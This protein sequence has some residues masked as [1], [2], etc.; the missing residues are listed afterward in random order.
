[1]KEKL[2]HD[3]VPGLVFF[4]PLVPLRTTPS[5]QFHDLPGGFIEY[6]HSIDRVHHDVGAFS[7]IAVNRPDVRAWYMHP[8]Q[9]DNLLVLGGE[10]V[11]ELYTST[12]GAIETFVVT[13]NSI[14]HRGKEIH[15]GPALLGW[16]T[17]VFHRVTSPQGSISMNFARHFPNF[18]LDT[19]FNIYDVDVTAGTYT[20]L[21]EGKTDQPLR[22]VG[23]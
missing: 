19:N 9:E 20:L 17:H 8:D 12:H 22:D 6:I 10:R 1:M 7:P 21:R 2:H 13:P 15:S 23:E 18:D 5:V 3:I 16:P 11:V 14:V 4:I